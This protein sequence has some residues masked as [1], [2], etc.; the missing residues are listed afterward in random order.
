[1]SNL[2]AKIE[3]LFEKPIPFDE[4]PSVGHLAGKDLPIMTKRLIMKDINA[5]LQMLENMSWKDISFNQSGTSYTVI[6][7][8]NIIEAI[9]KIIAGTSPAFNTDFY[10]N[11][12]NKTSF[13]SVAQQQVQ[14]YFFT[15]SYRFAGISLGG[16]DIYMKIDSDNRTH[17]PNSG[18]SDKLKGSGLGK[19]LYRKLIEQ[20]QW[21]TT[22]SGGSEIKDWMWAALSHEQFDKNGRRDKDAEIYSFRFSSALYAVSTTRADK[23]EGGYQVISKIQ[24]K[25]KLATKE[26]R[27]ANNIG[28]D[29]DFIAYCKTVKT[30]PK[31]QQIL[32]WCNPSPAAQ[33]RLAKQAEALIKDR[34]MAYCGVKKISQLSSDWEI[35]DFIVLKSYLLDQN[36]Q[37][38]VRKVVR[39][40]G[41]IW[42]AQNLAGSIDTRETS[43][44]N[45]WVKALP[46]AA[47]YNYPP[48]LFGAPATANR[49][50]VA[51][52]SSTTSTIGPTPA[53]ET[54]RPTNNNISLSDITSIFTEPFDNSVI[55]RHPP[56]SQKVVKRNAITSGVYLINNP[57]LNNNYKNPRNNVPSSAFI[58]A[59]SSIR[60]TKTLQT[61]N[62]NTD[63][64]NFFSVH[65]TKYNVSE[66]R[67]KTDVVSGDLVL[68]TKHTRYYGYVAK[69]D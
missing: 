12:S 42:K 69:V 16:S 30:Q 31:A 36:Y 5:I 44:K 22:N 53:P 24:D 6:L 17:F 33:R 61:A 57:Y 35:G 67:E 8:R 34:L 46:P 65:A 59:G 56:I 27:L 54:T 37:T 41:N 39:K 1:M 38:P 50:R 19:K 29:A 58:I 40:D 2:K 51:R 23:L 20:K 49:M 26:L 14:T 63:I 48:G 55:L 10:R 4:L 64:I 25:T 47:G 45:S 60:N 9:N 62:V 13:K 21:V 11:L 52:S 68:I 43:D 66:L 15:G 18:I 7:P 3:K 28:I 32:D